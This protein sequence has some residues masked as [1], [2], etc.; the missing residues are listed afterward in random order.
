M[1]APNVGEYKCEYECNIHF[2]LNLV[3][4]LA[5]KIGDKEKGENIVQY[6]LNGEQ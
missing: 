2:S 5:K 6:F 3:Y 1:Y 4:A